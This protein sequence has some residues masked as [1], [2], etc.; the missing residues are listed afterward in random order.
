MVRD[1]SLGVKTGKGFYEWND[2]KIK[3]VM[4]RRDAG[5]LELIKL[6]KKL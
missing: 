2:A 1:G 3:N 5:L 6:R 4:N